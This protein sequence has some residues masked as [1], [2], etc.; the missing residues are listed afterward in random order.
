MVDNLGENGQRN[1]LSVFYLA[2][3]VLLIDFVSSTRLKVSIIGL[4]SYLWYLFNYNTCR[5][6][7]YKTIFATLLT[8][9]LFLLNLHK[10]KFHFN[11]YKYVL[12]FSFYSFPLQYVQKNLSTTILKDVGKLLMNARILIF[13]I[14]CIAVG[15]CTGV[16]WNFLLWLL[17]D[18]AHAYSEDSNKWIT[19]LEGL[20][21]AIQCLAGELPFFFLSSWILKRIGHVNAMTLVLA[22]IGV[23]YILYSIVV[24]PW[25]IL[26]IEILNGITFGLAYASMASYACVIA[27]PGTSTTVQVK[28]M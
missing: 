11:F 24:N 27:P 28:Y 23:R 20:A 25:L 26:P 1:Y 14:W 22:V 15:L 21:M 8:Q 19:T 16:I 7:I 9:N 4:Y 12:I 17:E 6:F 2:F 13:I 10:R 18:L 3:V 5:K